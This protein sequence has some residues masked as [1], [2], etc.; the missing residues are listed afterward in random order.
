MQPVSMP[1]LAKLLMELSKKNGFKLKTNVVLLVTVVD[2]LK[3]L[4]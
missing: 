4:N 3:V 1:F 2:I